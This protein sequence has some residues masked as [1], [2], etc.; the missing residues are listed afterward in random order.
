M[1]EPRI[2][3]EEWAILPDS[4]RRTLASTNKLHTLHIDQ[5][6]NKTFALNKEDVNLQN[7]V[8]S[9]HMW[10]QQW[11]NFYNNILCK[12]YLKIEK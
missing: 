12:C 1:Q 10:Q 6:K 5:T 9:H 3:L 7:D 4:N 11:W 2:Q 8:G